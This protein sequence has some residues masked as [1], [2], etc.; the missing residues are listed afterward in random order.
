MSSE[1][2]VASSIYHTYDAAAGQV[3][4]LE[5]ISFSLESET[6]TCLVGPSGCGKSTLLRILAGLVQPESGHVLLN[7][8]P[9]NVP[10][11]KIGLV[12]QDATL[13]PWRTVIQNMTLPLEFTGISRA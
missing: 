7:G 1:S 5:N 10:Q 3:S 8:H 13:M 6:F 9:L 4:A 11:R 2:L 12:F